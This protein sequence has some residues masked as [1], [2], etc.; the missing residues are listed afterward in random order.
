MRG[1]QEEWLNAAALY[2]LPLWVHPRMAS[3]QYM[4]QRTIYFVSHS[5]P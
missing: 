2:S 4:A 5:P 1:I 3:A